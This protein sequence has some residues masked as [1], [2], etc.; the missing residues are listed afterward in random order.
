M[1]F[2]RAIGGS[3]GNGEYA[4]NSGLVVDRTPQPVA[5]IMEVGAQRP[6][7]RA[8]LRGALPTK[9]VGAKWHAPVVHALASM[10]NLNPPKKLKPGQTWKVFGL[11][12][13]QNS[14]APRPASIVV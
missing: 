8:E 1:S 6:S 2:E 5:P 14:S 12:T 10:P 13:W 7:R 3:I 4:D 11:Q 9:G